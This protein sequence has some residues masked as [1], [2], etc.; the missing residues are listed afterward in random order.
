S[1]WEANSGAGNHKLTDD[2]VFQQARPIVIG[3]IES[4]TYNQWLPAVLGFG[5]TKPYRRYDA[6]LNPVIANECSTAAFRFGHSLLGDDVEFMDNDGSET[7]DEIP[8][9]AAFFNP[10]VV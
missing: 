10:E 9:A 3:E 1:F 4:I 8:L 7:Q 2:E 6:T 5:A